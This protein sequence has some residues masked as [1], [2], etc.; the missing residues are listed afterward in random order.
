MSGGASIP[1]RFNPPPGWPV[2][3][4]WSPS[5]D[6]EPD[7]LWPPAPRGWQF[8]VEAGPEPSF[9]QVPEPQFTEHETR[10][11]QRF[12]GIG[13]FAGFGGEER[14]G[15]S[16]SP[17]QEAPTFGLG[18][19]NRRPGGRT[20][21]LA[22]AAAAVVVLVVAVVVIVFNRD[23]GPEIVVLKPVD[24]QGN[25]Q[26][27]WTVS[28]SRGSQPIDCSFGTPSPFD[29]TD[30]VRW[31]G[32][33][34]DDGAACWP[35]DSSHVLCVFDAFSNVVDLVV[36][37]GLSTPRKPDTTGAH[38]FALI[39]D[40]GTQCTARIGGSWGTPKE[41]P[42]WVGYFGCTG[43]GFVAVWASGGG[44]FSNSG[45]DPN[46]GINK[47]S[48]GWTVVVGPED[49]HLTTH[50]VTKAYYVGVAGVDDGTGGTSSGSQSGGGTRMVTKC[51]R[52]PEFKPETIRADSGALVIRMK[53]VAHCP[54]GDVLNSATTRVTV[55]SGGSN[56]AAGVFDLS[57]QPIVIPPGGGDDP[58]GEHDFRFPVG[59]FWRLPVSTREVPSNGS[60]QQGGVDLDAKTLVVACDQSGSSQPS[61]QSSAN[62]DSASTAVGPASPASGDN[63][64]ASFDA[65]RALANSDHGFVTGQLADRW[66]PQ[67]SSKRP[68]LVA[69]G[70]TWDNA[71]TLREHLQLRLNYPE[72]RLLWSGD[73]ST[74]SAPD[75]WVT[76]AGVTFSDS[77]GA[78]A[79][80]H[81]HNLDRDHCYAKLVSTTHPV[82]GSTT[83]NR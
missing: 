1:R 46:F 45:S 52:T 2:P 31:C 40:D 54:G 80:C 72:V 21:L 27:G 25:V 59:T 39:L 61:A 5:P 19:F 63:E 82:D 64:S 56:V 66:V 8:W 22:A 20:G 49:G 57:S 29:K 75:F 18:Q 83:Y 77:D 26:A 16:P 44:G 13:E 65:L 74:F 79:W 7:P 43:T 36:A 24:S 73:W 30:G 60:S 37:Q 11:P 53:I 48:D 68:G 55:T 3:P 62:P 34:A 58:S 38:P 47:D 50:K 71:A 14:R 33:T 12:G 9:V 35:A 28:H 6:W 4:G 67:L 32:A 10:R 78:L 81:A 76:V 41:H 15:P 23:D 51:G 42:D 70:I 69:D 17:A